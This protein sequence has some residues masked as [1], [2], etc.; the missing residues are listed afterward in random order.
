[1]LFSRPALSLSQQRSPP[2][3]GGRLWT[4]HFRQ[5][6]LKLVESSLCIQHSLHLIRSMQWANH[7]IIFIPAISCFHF[8][9]RLDCLFRSL[10]T[11]RCMYI[12]S[13]V[14]QHPPFEH[15]LAFWDL[16]CPCPWVPNLV[17]WQSSSR[18]TRLIFPDFLSLPP[19]PPGGQDSTFAMHS[20][21]QPP[22]VVV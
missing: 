5:R 2:S 16:K 1:M 22:T 17:R 6:H 19:F 8:D 10:P 21:H 12:P 15:K 7:T 11:P 4:E 13:V 20:L 14:T 18:S 9:G 3:K